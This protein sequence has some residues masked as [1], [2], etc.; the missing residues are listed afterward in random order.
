MFFV[1][2]LLVVR[3]VIITIG[4]RDGGF[5]ESLFVRKKIQENEGKL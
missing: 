2:Q 1:T 5:F 3:R 4:F